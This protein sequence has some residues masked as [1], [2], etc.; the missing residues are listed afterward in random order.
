MSQYNH[1][2]AVSLLPSLTELVCKLGL[3]NHLIGR[4]HECDYPESTA[5]LPVLT[6]P[7]Y[8]VSE[9]D[10]SDDI[11]QSVTRMVQQGLSV[12]E[13]FDEKLKE[14][15]P[16]LILTQDH[17]EVCAVSF[18]ELKNS[19]SE[20]LNDS[21]QVISVSPT[22]TNQ[23]FDSFQTVA[24]AFDVPERGEK[25]NH[26]IK[27]C[28]QA[29]HQKIVSR[30]KPTVAAI[31]WMD[32]L[33]TGGNWMP[34]LIECAGG[35][36]LLAETG[37]HSPWISWEQLRQ[38]NPDILLILP[39]GYTIDKTLAEI[40]ALRSY[41]K[42]DTLNA[43]K[44]NRVYVLD[45]NHYFNRSGPRIKESTEIL[46]EIFHPEVFE[47]RHKTTGWIPLLNLNAIS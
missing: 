14:L 22:N 17:C 44:N 19:V 7:K 43:V 16:D 39:C 40:N 38:S 10:S 12:Y 34:E 32:P 31:E 25:L 45:G 29:I 24:N 47:T 4:S 28:F 37:K 13:V 21:T 26:E 11:H 20:L 33:M 9:D 42:W 15:K 41:H 36:P 3:E 1:P 5:H 18:T 30:A 46:A 6:Q 35:K 27:S 2:K 8:P 23:I